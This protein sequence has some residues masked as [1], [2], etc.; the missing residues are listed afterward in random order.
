VQE[1]VDHLVVRIV[2]R[3]EYGE[4]D[5]ETLLRGLRER[6]GSSMRIELRLVEAIPRSANGKYRWVISKVPLRFGATTAENLFW[7]DASRGL[8]IRVD[9]PR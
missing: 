9:S 2:P 1:A 7:E 8:E 4:R 6:L 5:A 3:A